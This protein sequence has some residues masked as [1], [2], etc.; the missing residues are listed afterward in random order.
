VVRIADPTLGSASPEQTIASVTKSGKDVPLG[1]EL[2]VK[3]GRV[4]LHIGVSCAQATHPVRRGHEAK[5]PDPDAAGT[6][7]RTHC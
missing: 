6:L 7:Q 5:K 2:S 1:V 4:D 3:S